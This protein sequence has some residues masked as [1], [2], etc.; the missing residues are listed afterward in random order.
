MAAATRVVSKY[1][2]TD[3]RPS[4]GVTKTVSGV[5]TVANGS[6]TKKDDTYVASAELTIDITGDVVTL[7]GVGTGA[8][9]FP[10]K[11]PREN[12]VEYYLT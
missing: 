6:H 2:V 12:L 8:A 3:P 7:T 9:T 4:A 5:Q 11:F 1:K 10:T